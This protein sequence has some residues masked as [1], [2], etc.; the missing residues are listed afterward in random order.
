MRKVEVICGGCKKKLSIDMTRVVN[1][2]RDAMGK[3]ASTLEDKLSR[4]LFDAFLSTQDAPDDSGTGR[5]PQL[6]LGEELPFSMD[7]KPG[8]ITII[9][10]SGR[11]RV[12]RTL[13]SKTYKYDVECPNC[14]WVLHVGIP[15]GVTI[16]DFKDGYPGLCPE[17]GCP[18]VPSKETKP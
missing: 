5:Y 6:T 16:E 18:M 9:P 1:V 7:L 12:Y 2:I 13:E 14:F 3:A 15:F 17:C 8:T 4:A 11:S 10:L